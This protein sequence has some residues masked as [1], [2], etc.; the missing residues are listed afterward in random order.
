MIHKADVLRVQCT[1]SLDRP[2]LWERYCSLLRR[3]SLTLVIRKSKSNKSVA[4]IRCVPVEKTLHH[5]PVEFYVQVNS[6]QFSV[7]FW[8]LFV[9]DTNWTLYKWSAVE[10][11]VK[12]IHSKGG[13]MINHVESPVWTRSSGEE[14]DFAYLLC[15]WKNSELLWSVGC[16]S[17]TDQTGEQTGQLCRVKTLYSWQGPYVPPPHNDRTHWQGQSFSPK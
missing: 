5:S 9:Y 2:S 8:F 14:S 13:E 15:R 12:T 17:E 11:G 3:K 4:R 7:I 16:N 1:M 10:R 6:T